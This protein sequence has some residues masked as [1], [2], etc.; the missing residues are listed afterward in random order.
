MLR[1]RGRLELLAELEQ[2]VLLAVLHVGTDAY[3]VPVRRELESRL[4]RRVSR[5][6]VYVTLDRLE[7]KGYLESRVGDP[8]PERGG[9]ARRYYAATRRGRAVLAESRLAL[10]RMWDGIQPI[11]GEA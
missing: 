10:T 1:Q 5:G 11:G 2:F 7:A 3:G 4:Q 6:A 8:S 9:R